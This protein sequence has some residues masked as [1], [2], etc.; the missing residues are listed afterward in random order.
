[1][2][3]THQESPIWNHITL[4]E[5]DDREARSQN[6]FQNRAARS[7]GTVGN[8]A[9]WAGLWNIP[10]YSPVQ[11]PIADW[12][13]ILDPQSIYKLT[14]ALQVVDTCLPEPAAAPPPASA[15]ATPAEE[16]TTPATPAVPTPATAAPAQ[17]TELSTTAGA[18]G[19]NEGTHLSA[20][21][22]REWCA[23]FVNAGGVRHL[24]HILLTADFSNPGNGGTRRHFCLAILAR[25]LDFFLLDPTFRSAAG[26]RWRSPPTAHSPSLT[27]P[28][29]RIPTLCM[30][31]ANV[32]GTASS[33]AKCPLIPF[34][35]TSSRP[36]YRTVQRHRP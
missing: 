12:K 31:R 33:D 11:A 4:R 28:T 36:T 13:E 17:P 18:N 15:A 23:R 27:C 32:V 22:Q 9:A 20:A 6:S 5:A 16:G 30:P 21:E 29:F 7:A 35:K 26:D 2:S 8:R 1:M 10:S 34:V 14:Y 3:N 25:L 24:L 19:A